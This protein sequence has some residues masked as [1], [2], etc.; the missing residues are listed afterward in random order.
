M[1]TYVA[2]STTPQ[3][4]YPD[5]TQST[6]NTNPIVFDARGEANVWLDPILAYKFV[7]YDSSGTLL[8]TTD[9]INTFNVNT[10]SYGNFTATCTGFASKT[11][12]V[13]YSKNGNTV[14]MEI[15]SFSGTSNST[16]FGLSGIPTTLWPQR[17]TEFA[18]PDGAAVDNGVSLTV[19]TGNAAT[20]RMNANGTITFNKNFNS[21]W[22]AS[23]TKGMASATESFTFTYNLT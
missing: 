18:I 5:F 15:S 4:T 8:G 9:N 11:T 23:G 22:T 2:G 19:A 3:A 16:S 13:H 20:G 12:T 14:T 7:E 1:W 6:P 10:F 21:T 17:T